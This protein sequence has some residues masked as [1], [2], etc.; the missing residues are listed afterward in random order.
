MQVLNLKHI[1]ELIQADNVI[2]FSRP[3]PNSTMNAFIGKMKREGFEE[4]GAG[5]MALVFHKPGA[6]DVLKAF[7]HDSC[8]VKFLTLI[9]N[10]KQDN[11][12][13]KII[14]YQQLKTPPYAGLHVVKMEKLYKTT[15]PDEYGSGRAC[16]IYL[17]KPSEENEKILKETLQKFDQRNIGLIQTVKLLASMPLGSCNIDLHNDN[18]MRRKDRT[19]VIIDPYI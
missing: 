11:H 13:P 14:D 18:I 3:E 6:N 4:L 9:S 16:S 7:R 15:T 12:L 17:N 19:L 1:L 5:T 10:N 2:D 8:Y